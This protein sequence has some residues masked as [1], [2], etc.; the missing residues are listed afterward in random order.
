MSPAGTAARLVAMLG[1][2][3]SGLVLLGEVPA[4]AAGCAGSTGVTVVVD[5]HQLGGGVR[6]A[7]D[8]DGG[9]KAASTVF[10]DSGFPLAYVQRQP[11]FVCR[12]SGAPASDPCV[13]TPPATAY[14]SLWWSD[15]TSGTWTYASVGVGSLKVPDGGYLAFSWQGQDGKAAPGVAPNPRAAPSSP[16][17]SP[18][19]G[20]SG[21]GDGPTHGAG[22]GGTTED[23]SRAPDTGG[24]SDGAA[25]PMPDGTAPPDPGAGPA[26]GPSAAGRRQAGDTSEKPR[27]SGSAAPSPGGTPGA[28]DKL[29][30]DSPPSGGDS[31]DRAGAP[32]GGNLLPAWVSVLAVGGLLAAAVSVAA[33]RAR[34][35][36]S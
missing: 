4:A 7:C 14:W 5:F 20:E 25:P 26:T 21:G 15:G 13:N 30:L 27:R 18:G 10:P 17:P 16:S 8:A 19:T 31:D 11:G 3:A 33:V 12:V 34:R 35:G 9:G 22:P 36:R 29:S 24:G 28:A 1:L 32:S 6:Q 2:V 23:G